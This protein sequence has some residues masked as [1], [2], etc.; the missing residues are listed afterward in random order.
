MS[1]REIADDLTSRIRSGEYP[2]GAEL[3]SSAQI[4]KLYS[5]GKSTADGA[6]AL[7]RERGLTVG[8][9]GRGTYVAEPETPADPAE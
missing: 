6:L 9:R 2:P 7:L 3:P 4:A 8:H 1:Y 5:V